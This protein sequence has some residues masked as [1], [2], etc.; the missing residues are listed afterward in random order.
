MLEPRLTG[1]RTSKT[2]TSEKKNSLSKC[3]LQNISIRTLIMV[4]VEI[5]TKTLLV[6]F[7]NLLFF[8]IVKKLEAIDNTMLY[9][10]LM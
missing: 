7:E 5:K 8:R 4:L 1:D 9:D 3:Y 2:S 10:Y 6:R